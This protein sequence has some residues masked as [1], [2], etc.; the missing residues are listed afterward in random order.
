MRARTIM[1]MRTDKFWGASVNQ[2]VNGNMHAAL[3][4]IMQT[5]ASAK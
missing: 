2:L 5:S 3:L 1:H 4:L